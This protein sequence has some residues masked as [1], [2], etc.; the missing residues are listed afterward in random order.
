MA[1]VQVSVPKAPSV[2]RPL[3]KVW[4]VTPNATFHPYRQTK[5]VCYSWL[6]DSDGNLGGS[7]SDNM[8]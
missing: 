1:Q 4:G 8:D 5:G 2:M 6:C 3:T 7:V